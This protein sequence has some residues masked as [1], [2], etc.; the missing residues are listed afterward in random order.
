MRPVPLRFALRRQVPQTLDTSK[1]YV[2]KR[3]VY[4]HNQLLGAAKAFA[5]QAEDGNEFNSAMACALFCALALESALNYIGN[6][7]FAVWDVHL[8]KKLSPEGKLALITSHTQHKID[9]SQKPFQAFRALFQLRNQLAHGTT[10]DISYGTAK[11]WLVYGDCRWPAAQW[12]PLCTAEHA[13]S[14]LA[15]TEQMITILHHIS[16]MEEVPP[17]LLSEHVTHAQ[18]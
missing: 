6:G 18:D 14:L 2:V 7:V 15:D 8:Q 5:K 17:F 3:R 1:N 4:T 10:R 11:H 16:G 9:F 12:E 13:K